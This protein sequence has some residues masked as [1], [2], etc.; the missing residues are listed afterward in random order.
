MTLFLGQ[1]MRP[2]IVTIMGPTGIG[3]TALAMRLY[4]HIPCELM[5]VDA[6]MVYQGL[7]IGTAKPTKELLLRYPHALVDVTSPDQVFSVSNFL[8]AVVPWIE[9]AWSSKKMPVLVGGTMM[10][11][12][13]LIHGISDLPSADEAIR[14]ELY[15]TGM[16]EGWPKLWAS[17]SLIDPKAAEKIKPNDQ[18]RIQR[19]LEVYRLTGQPISQFWSETHS[20]LPEETRV[21]QTALLP[22]D[23]AWLYTRLDERFQAMLDQGWVVEVQ[24]ALEQYPNAPALRSVGYRQIVDFIRHDTSEKHMI[25]EAQ[26]A[27]RRLAKRQ[28]TWLNRWVGLHSYEVDDRVDVAGIFLSDFDDEVVS[29]LL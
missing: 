10:Y 1:S 12:H 25:E 27:T 2:W 21:W 5:S 28:C 19:A 17:L 11:F 16:R 20:V 13:A 9:A 6:M 18:Q 3:K 7:D 26:R 24:Q 29:K 23:R 8:E 22:R 4:D 14:A 15:E